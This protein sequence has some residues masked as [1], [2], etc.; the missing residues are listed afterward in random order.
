MRLRYNDFSAFCRLARRLAGNLGA[1]ISSSTEDI[2][3][4]VNSTQ[5]VKRLR[6]AG[7]SR[8]LIRCQPL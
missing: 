3:R 4:A 1:A 6:H 8:E 5:S 7:F 2:G